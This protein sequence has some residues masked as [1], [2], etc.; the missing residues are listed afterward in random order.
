MLALFYRIIPNLYRDA[1]TLGLFEKRRTHQEPFEHYLR[2]IF[3]G[4]QRRASRLPSAHDA[5]DDPTHSGTR[6]PRLDTKSG[7]YKTP[8][9][10]SVRNYIPKYL[11]AQYICP[12]GNSDPSVSIFLRQVSYP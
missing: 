10:I 7:A 3:A 9:P 5:R 1:K 11:P 8:R 6:R 4:R 2:P 12:R